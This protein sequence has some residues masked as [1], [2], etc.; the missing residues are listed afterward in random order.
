MYMSYHI[1]DLKT[2]IDCFAGQVLQNEKSNG[3][4]VI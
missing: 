2:F 4:N 3:S 1:P